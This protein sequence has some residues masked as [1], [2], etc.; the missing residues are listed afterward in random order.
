MNFLG[1][2]A[3]SPEINEVLTGNLIGDFVKGNI[4]N[5]DFSD[6]IK[7]G[8]TLHRSIDS[9]TDADPSIDKCKLLFRADHGLYS[10]AIMDVVCDYFIAND[11]AFFPSER[12]LLNFTQKVHQNVELH[13]PQ[14]PEKFQMIFPYMKNE[15]WMLQVRNFGG[16]K[17]SLAGLSRRSGGKIDNL[18]AFEIFAANYYALNQHYFDFIERISRYVKTL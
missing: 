17:K 16:L 4:E 3:L 15:N 10:G 14:L 7:K 12:D 5:T 9:Y 13:L 2:A 1:H 8:L 6:G 18:K 11:P